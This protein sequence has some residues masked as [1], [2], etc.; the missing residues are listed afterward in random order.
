M[1]QGLG[2]KSN[3][4]E[5]KRTELIWRDRQQEVMEEAARVMNRDT[6]TTQT[7]GFIGARQTALASILA[8]LTAGERNALDAEVTRIAREGNPEDLKRR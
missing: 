2:H 7:P 8:G 1:S 4:W 6:I 3:N 5:P